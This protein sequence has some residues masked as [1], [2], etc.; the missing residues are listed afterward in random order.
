M[1]SIAKYF[2][3]V[4]K[5]APPLHTCGRTYKVRLNSSFASEEADYKQ[6]CYRSYRRGD[7]ASQHIFAAY[8][9]QGEEPSSQHASDYTYRKIE[10]EAGAGSFNYEAGDVAGRKTYEYIP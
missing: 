8:S 5:L 4:H 1:F 9:H 6:K 10:Q 3:V 2:K 7:E